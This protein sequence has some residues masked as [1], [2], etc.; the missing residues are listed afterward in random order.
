MSHPQ[1]PLFSSGL[2]VPLTD[3]A[4]NLPMQRFDSLDLPR[5][6]LDLEKRE[7]RLTKSPIRSRY[8]LD[9]PNYYE[10]SPPQDFEL[11]QQFPGVEDPRLTEMDSPL[12]GFYG[13]S[14][15]SPNPPEPTPAVNSDDNSSL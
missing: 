4:R 13:P 15:S 1:E 6:H 2:K 9:D 10:S 5:S 14:K 12:V 8:E 11:E 3:L 7:E